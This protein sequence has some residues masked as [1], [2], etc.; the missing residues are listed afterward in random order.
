MHSPWTGRNGRAFGVRH[1]TAPAR[2]QVRAAA[3]PSLVMPELARRTARSTEESWSAARCPQ[4]RGVGA[5]LRPYQP[6]RHF[7][8][9]SAGL[10]ASALAIETTVAIAAAGTC[11]HSRRRTLA[12]DSGA[13][14]LGKP[15]GRICFSLSESPCRVARLLTPEE[16]AARQVRRHTSPREARRASGR[17][18]RPSPAREGRQARHRRKRDS[19]RHRAGQH[20]SAKG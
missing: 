14:G 3:P 8:L 4:S 6:R 15:R 2:A 5:R 10:S 20:R 9:C 1:R 18:F 13:L 17:N 11:D 12:S 19:S 7:A 16:E